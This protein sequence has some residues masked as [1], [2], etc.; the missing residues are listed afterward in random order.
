MAPK[1]SI[2]VVVQ[3]ILEYLIR[4]YF[5]QKLLIRITFFRRTR[6]ILFVDCHFFVLHKILL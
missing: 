1:F 2:N 4:D 6:D 3:I 5:Y